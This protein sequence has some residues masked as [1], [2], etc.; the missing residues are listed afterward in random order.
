[1]LTI[2]SI[3]L[4]LDRSYVMQTPNL[5]PIW[6]MGLL[7][8]R[9]QLASQRQ[10]QQQGGGA[11]LEAK[12]IK[13]LLHLIERQRNG[14]AVNQQL[15]RSLVRMLSSL[16]LYKT[17]FLRAFLEDTERY[18]AAEGGKRMETMDV[19]AFLLH[20]E[21][22]LLE[23][24][25]SPYAFPCLKIKRSESCLMGT[26]LPYHYITLHA[27]INIGFRC[28]SPIP[29]TRYSQIISSSNR[30]TALGTARLHSN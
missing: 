14:E 27:C 21:A 26:Y 28:C 30:S 25:I 6:E 2:R 10:L 17:S 5:L 16:G 22:R 8:F 11:G 19:V 7:L 3:F 29:R 9:Q 20:V 1:M 23:V 24:N 12:I 18:F 13:G 15:L 4:Y